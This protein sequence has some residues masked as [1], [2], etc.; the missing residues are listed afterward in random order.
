MLLRVLLLGLDCKAGFVTVLFYAERG[1][2]AAR[3]GEGSEEVQEKEGTH[4]G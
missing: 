2:L 1:G 3:K 4:V